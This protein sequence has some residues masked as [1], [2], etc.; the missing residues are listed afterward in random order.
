MDGAFSSVDWNLRISISMYIH[1]ENEVT[2]RDIDGVGWDMSGPLKL[3]LVLG[4]NGS[5]FPQTSA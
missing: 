3:F 5:L 1:R 4:G 2:E